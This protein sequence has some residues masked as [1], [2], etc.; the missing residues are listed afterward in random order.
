MKQK[1][2]SHWNYRV[3]KHSDGTHDIHE[4]YY[5]KRGRATR[6]SEGPMI[7]YGESVD[8]LWH[9]MAMMIEATSKPV[10][11]PPKKWGVK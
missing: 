5:D 2:K 3:V 4:V 9:I 6:M 7:P 11:V 8:D 1:T 10:F